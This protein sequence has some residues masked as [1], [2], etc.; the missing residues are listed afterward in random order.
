M[1]NPKSICNLPKSQDIYEICPLQSKN[2]S[3]QEIAKLNF[4]DFV[5][6]RKHCQV[7]LIHHHI[8]FIIDFKSSLPK[9]STVLILH[10]E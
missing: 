7:T 2:K 4:A 6:Y 1:S 9:T 8:P 10:F 5:P 3:D